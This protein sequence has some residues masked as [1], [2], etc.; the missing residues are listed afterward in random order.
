MVTG[1]K[2]PTTNI[3]LGDERVRMMRSARKLGAIMGTAP[4]VVDSTETSPEPCV[5]P[6]GRT[7]MEIALPVLKEA[8]SRNS[9]RSSKREG[10]VF[11]VSSRSSISSLESGE[12]TPPGP[13]P[14]VA[15]LSL[16]PDSRNSLNSVTRL[17]LVL[18]LTQPPYPPHHP[19][20]CSTDSIDLLTR[21]LSVFISTP[22][23]SSDQAARRRKM[24]KLVNML[25]GPIPP[26]L[27]FPPPAKP[28]QQSARDRSSRRRS[29]SVP[30]SSYSTATASP[31]KLV[32]PQHPEDLVLPALSVDRISHPRPLAAY[33][34]SRSPTSSPS[35]TGTT[36][37]AGSRGRPRSVTPSYS[38]RRKG[39]DSKY[40]SES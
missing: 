39:R 38:L 12:K 10:V 20:H 24:V 25:G 14:Q 3:L 31:R 7:T 13:L 36:S 17:R 22:P 9:H 4:L 30:P 23:P 28:R 26:A 16:S 37:T 35:S 6:L 34:H 29:R 11:T 32:R 2:P 21:S 18:T 33:A 15:K 8:P 40:T 19:H 1:G 27:V 5:L